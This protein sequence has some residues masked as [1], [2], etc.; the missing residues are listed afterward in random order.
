MR[1]SLSGFLDDSAI[2][3]V[4][5]RV[6]AHDAELIAARPIASETTIA[7]PSPGDIARN[8][9]TPGGNSLPK[10]KLGVGYHPVTPAIASMLHAEA[11]YGVAIARV[12]AGSPAERAGIQLGDI[13]LA[14]NG[15][16]LG[17][18]LEDLPNALQKISSG[19]VASMSVLRGSIMKTLSV[20]F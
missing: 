1:S 10:P 16:P 11:T 15:T 14:V 7:S 8:E 20:Q 18:N 4:E 12:D 6:A 2:P 17:H 9:V 19:E 5:A 13:I 3:K